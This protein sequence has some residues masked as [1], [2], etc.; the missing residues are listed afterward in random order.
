MRAFGLHSRQLSS[1]GHWDPSSSGRLQE[2]DALVAPEPSLQPLKAGLA[3]SEAEGKVWPF[4]GQ[5]TGKA[6]ADDRK[7]ENRVRSLGYVCVVAGG[8]RPRDRTRCPGC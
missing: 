5:L 3:S 8:E 7:L 4:P 1:T 6:K 2:Q